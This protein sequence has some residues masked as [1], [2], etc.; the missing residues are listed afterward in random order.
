[1]STMRKQTQVVLTQ[2]DL[3]WLVER[4]NSF[5]AAYNSLGGKYNKD[6]ANLATQV[7][8]MLA[9]NKK[10]VDSAEDFDEVLK[11]RVAVFMNVTKALEDQFN[12]FVKEQ[13]KKGNMDYKE[14]ATSDKHNY[15]KIIASTLA[16]IYKD[17]P[18]VKSILDDQSS[19]SRDTLARVHVLNNFGNLSDKYSLECSPRDIV[20]IDPSVEISQ[21]RAAWNNRNA[22]KDVDNRDDMQVIHGEFNTL[23]QE[24]MSMLISDLKTKRD[25]MLDVN[26]EN[27]PNATNSPSNVHVLNLL[28][29]SLSDEISNGNI[30]ADRLQNIKNDLAGI[31]KSNETYKPLFKT[32]GF[33]GMFKGNDM[34]KLFKKYEGEFDVLKARKE[35]IV[36]ADVAPAS[37]GMKND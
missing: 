36:N 14:I 33:G 21:E 12:I 6:I 4:V 30:T 11:K 35:L 2:G 7:N 26:K 10:A 32:G 3:D 16:E 19:V 1:M 37:K 18:A 13:N 29:R 5:K 15:H 20:A 8:S 22:G 27:N 23:T 28:I 34:E 31:R 24:L 25:N 17:Y 9:E